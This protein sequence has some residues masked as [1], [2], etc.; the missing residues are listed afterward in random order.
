MTREDMT[1]E[2]IAKI[3]SG[4]KSLLSEP[5][6]PFSFYI[7]DPIFTL[8]CIMI[9]H[10]GPP[11]ALIYSRLTMAGSWRIVKLEDIWDRVPDEFKQEA[12]FHL[13]IFERK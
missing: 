13:E 11:H 8:T 9:A 7:K 12:A 5:S 6:N 1:R 2:D 10:Y 4:F 3:L